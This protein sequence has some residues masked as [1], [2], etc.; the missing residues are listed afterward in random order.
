MIIERQKKEIA[1]KEKAGEDIKSFQTVLKT[2]EEKLRKMIDLGMEGLADPDVLIETDEEKVKPISETD[3]TIKYRK[4]DPHHRWFNVKYVPPKKW[5]EDP[6]TSR[7]EKPYSAPGTSEIEQEFSEDDYSKLKDEVLHSLDDKGKVDDAGNIVPPKS[8]GGMSYEDLLKIM[9]NAID[10]AGNKLRTNPDAWKTIFMK[11]LEKH[12]VDKGLDLKKDKLYGMRNKL[13]ADIQNQILTNEKFK[14]LKDNLV[15]YLQHQTLK[16]AADELTEKITKAWESPS[17]EKLRDAYTEALLDMEERDKG[18][19]KPVQFI[20]MIQKPTEEGFRKALE[21]SL[22][23][24]LKLL[25]VLSGIKPPKEAP[26][27]THAPSVPAITNEEKAFQHVMKKY[28]LPEEASK[29]LMDLIKVTQLQRTAPAQTQKQMKD[30]L[31]KNKITGEAAERIKAVFE[32]VTEMDYQRHDDP[33]FKAPDHGQGNIIPQY[34]KLKPEEKDKMVA[35]KAEDLKKRY[36][37]TKIN[38]ILPELGDYASGRVL[39]EKKPPLERSEDARNFL[40]EYP[41]WLSEDFAKLQKL[42]SKTK[43]A[44]TRANFD[45]MIDRLKKLFLLEVWHLEDKD[46]D[47]KVDLYHQYD[48][49]F[50]SDEEKNSNIIQV[51]TRLRDDIKQLIAENPMGV[52]E[53]P[54]TE[55]TP[56][57]KKVKVEKPTS[58]IVEKRDTDVLERLRKF[59]ETLKGAA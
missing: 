58:E 32:R 51:R 54:K 38:E 3:K 4:K 27:M 34:Q 26:G 47:Q 44:F 52:K 8:L 43:T 46:L 21:K 17:E 49:V 45:D 12:V 14:K 11:K 48:E 56:K 57:Q 35:D 36:P 1:E 24:A 6:S 50:P 59:R 29:E 39:N 41:G 53:D 31:E 42:L 2:N 23:E 7:K 55:K 22:S 37:G 40:K 16:K 13:I 19:G 20:A 30:I 5:L 28:S 33:T 15:R 25:S 10:A 9:W 18:V